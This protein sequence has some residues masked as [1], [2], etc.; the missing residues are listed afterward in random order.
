MNE[1]TSFTQLNNFIQ[2][3]PEDIKRKYQTIIDAP[4]FALINDVYINEPEPENIRASG[5]IVVEDNKLVWIRKVANNYGGYVYSFAKGRLES[6]LTIQQNAIKETLEETGFLTKITNW[7]MDI[8]GIRFYLGN[9]IGGSPIH[10]FVQ[11]V[12]ETE[13]IVL[14]TFDIARDEL[15]NTERD[16]YIIDRIKEKF[17]NGEV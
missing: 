12:P 10:V 1:L 4:T 8:N 6:S 5:V 7:L 15:L 17:D 16:K 11:D 9:I 14:T 3:N 13:F 2:F